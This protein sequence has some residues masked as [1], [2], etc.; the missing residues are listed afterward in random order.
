MCDVMMLIQHAIQFPARE[1]WGDDSISLDM[2]AGWL[3]S[4][5]GGLYLCV[6]SCCA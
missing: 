6:V 1:H 4:V 5:D 2:L 3:S